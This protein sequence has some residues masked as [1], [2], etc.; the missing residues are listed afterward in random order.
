MLLGHR[1]RNDTSSILEH[2]RGALQVFVFSR[3]STPSPMSRP[4]LDT[5]SLIRNEYMSYA[6]K[7][8]F[9]SSPTSKSPWTPTPSPAS[10]YTSSCSQSGVSRSR[11]MSPCAVADSSST[12]SREVVEQ[13][14]PIQCRGQ[15]LA[16]MPAGRRERRP[17]DA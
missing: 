14:A 1:C 3:C 10:I 13:G 9:H 16:T 7:W 17:Q 8:R 12:I 11:S 5:V 6:Y 15:W 4:I 2:G